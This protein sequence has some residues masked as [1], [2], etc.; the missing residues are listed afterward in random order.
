MPSSQSAKAL[1]APVVPTTRAFAKSN[2]DNSAKI[3]ILKR[4]LA[5]E[6]SQTDR[7]YLLIELSKLLQIPEPTEAIHYS[8]QALEVAI[9]LDDEEL[10]L[11]S[12][13][14]NITALYSGSQLP[15]ALCK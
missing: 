6:K 4:K 12:I 1:V 7:V 5:A 9:S 10:Q 3:K 13:M 11:K 14:A 15:S 8:E 2:A